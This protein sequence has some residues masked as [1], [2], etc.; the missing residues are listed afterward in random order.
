MMLTIHLPSLVARS[1][2]KC[3]EVMSGEMVQK[4]LTCWPAGCCMSVP[5][6]MLYVSRRYCKQMVRAAN[7]WWPSFTFVAFWAVFS[8]MVIP[9]EAVI[10]CGHCKDNILPSH[11][12]QMHAL[13]LEEP[14]KMQQLYR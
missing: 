8:W 1:T 3:V 9:A 4:I 14:L 11:G 12:N 6:D 5:R 13:W 7:S 10:R 2:S